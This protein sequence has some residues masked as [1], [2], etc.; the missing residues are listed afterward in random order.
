MKSFATLL[1]SA[2][3]LL[4]LG[5]TGAAQAQS[6]CCAKSQQ[7]PMM[8]ATSGSHPASGQAQSS[9]LQSKDGQQVQELK[10]EVTSS[11]DPSV[12]KVKKDIPVVLKAHRKDAN[13]CGG[14]LLIPE[15]GVKAQLPPGETTEVRFTPDKEGTFAFTC[16]MN[17]MRGQLV[18]ESGDAK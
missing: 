3:T 16:G 9:T 11:Y 13:N 15:F 1:A 2:A 8:A 10:L 5:S 18:V 6:S 12:L 7:C 14:E 4:L 17:M